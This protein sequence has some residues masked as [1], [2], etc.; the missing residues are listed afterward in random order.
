[1]YLKNKKPDLN[2]VLPVLGACAG[3]AW[4]PTW[5]LLRAAETSRAF[6]SG[7]RDVM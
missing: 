2:L 5:G 7:H 4:G 3:R 6:C 1:M